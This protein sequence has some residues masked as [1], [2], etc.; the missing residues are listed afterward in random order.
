MKFVTLH[1]CQSGP[2]NLPNRYANDKL[3]PDHWPKK[4]KGEF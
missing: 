2:V 3:M 1:F 4:K